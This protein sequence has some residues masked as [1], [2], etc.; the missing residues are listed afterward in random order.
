MS[1]ARR[2]LRQLLRYGI[3]GLA[4]NALGYLLYLALTAMGLAPV[5][6]M[7]LLYAVGVLQTFVFNKRWTFEHGGRGGPAF[8]RYVLLYLVGYGLNLALMRLLVGGLGWPH[9]A[10]MLGLVLGMPLFFFVGQKFWVFAPAPR[11]G[12]AL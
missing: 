12:E 9:Q 5:L 4:A 10:V 11:G 6:A 7:S 2:T 3:V 8:R 1:A